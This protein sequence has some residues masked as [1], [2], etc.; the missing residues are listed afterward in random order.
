[1]EFKAQ[2]SVLYK[3]LANASRLLS[4]KSSYNIENCFLIELTGNKL[5]I[6]GTD[7]ESSVTCVIT[8]E[9]DKVI[10]EGVMAVTKQLLEMLKN[11]GDTEMHFKYIGDQMQLNVQH[12]QEGID[13]GEF[14]CFCMDA[15]EYPTMPELHGDE[16]T[17]IQTTNDVLLTG[18]NK[19]LFSAGT[20]TITMPHI[21]GVLIEGK[22]EHL[23][24][25]ATNANRIACYTRTDV[26]CDGEHSVL[27]KTKPAQLLQSILS[28]G[29]DPLEI[30]FDSN[31]LQV[32][33]T[34]YTLTCRLSEGTFPDYEKVIPKD[35]PDRLDIDRVL[36]LNALK[37]VSPFSDKG[38][39]FFKLTLESGKN[40]VVIRAENRASS[41][42]IE[43]YQT[44]PA[45]YE[46]EDR[47]VYFT[48]PLIADALPII[49][50]QNVTIT[51]H[52]NL[53]NSEIRP[54]EKGSEF[55]DHFMVVVHSRNEY[56]SYYS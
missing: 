9:E 35:Y 34:S 55:E 3:Q 11:F 31:N 36:L 17:R 15:D 20:D 42:K 18:I 5:S 37:Q 16:I 41:G 49:S 14:N 30:A 54:L 6:M 19:T 50:S 21:C 53:K 25:V 45:S 8:L 48:T 24:F 27:L 4:A 28:D 47:E 26:H 12:G 46:G 10:S 33:T 52:P 13:K 51:F 2:S 43:A 39:N 22:P 40:T 23:R 38:R 56:D 7:T 32:T 29:E 1:M 44:L